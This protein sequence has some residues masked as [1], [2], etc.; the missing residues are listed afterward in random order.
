MKKYIQEE[1]LIYMKS[2]LM[3]KQSQRFR[4]LLKHLLL[5]KISIKVS[6][7]A[8]VAEKIKVHQQL[9]MLILQG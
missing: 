6:T 9:V 4:L 8:R 5:L 1:M 7:L 2:N 3:T